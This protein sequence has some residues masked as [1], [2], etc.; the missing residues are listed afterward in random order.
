[1]KKCESKKTFLKR[2]SASL[3]ITLVSTWCIGS[4]VPSQAA[5]ATEINEWTQTAMSDFQ[6]HVPDATK[7]MQEAKGFLI[8]PHL[9]NAGVIIGGKYAEGELL[10]NNAAS[11]YYNLLGLSWGWQLG[12]QRQSLIIAFMTD[13]A[14]AK[15]KKSEGWDLG[16]DATV[17]IVDAGVQG[18]MAISR[19]NKPVLA[20][21]VDQKGLMA[22]L[23]L[24]GSK[25]SKISK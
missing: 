3:L 2:L 20:F 19:F 16:T 24:Q 13:E 5:S 25:V 14:L 7:V 9:Y 11:G 12:G 22:G 1:M 21:A 10:V 6:K 8:F 17:A 15:F 23:S 18:Q 4:Q